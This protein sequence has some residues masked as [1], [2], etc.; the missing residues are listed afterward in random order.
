MLYP[1]VLVAISNTEN[2]AF[3]MR[4]YEENYRV[5]YAQAYDILHNRQD[6][7]DAI[8]DACVALIRNISKLTRMERP[9]LRAYVV[10]TVRNTSLNIRKRR[11]KEWDRAVYDPELAFDVITD[12]KAT[13]DAKML[14]DEEVAQVKQAILRLSETEQRV[15]TMKYYEGIENEEI[16]QRLG[17]KSESVRKCLLRARRH[18]IEIIEETE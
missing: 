11:S 1:I 13:V 10:S 3:M 6:V 15:V 9:V 8:S 7:E 17:V 4:L 16:G 5:M 14:L 12:D 18:I 2:R